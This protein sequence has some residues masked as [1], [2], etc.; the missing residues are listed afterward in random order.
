MC[1]FIE[2]Y[3][4]SLKKKHVFNKIV[5]F[6]PGDI[7]EIVFFRK[8]LPYTFEGICL[9]IK[10]KTLQDINSSFII[11]NVLSGIGIEYSI[12]YFYNRMYFLRR[13]DYKKKFYDIKRAKFF[14]LRN[15]LNRESQVK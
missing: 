7:L 11:R 3:N 2:N 14:Y 1:N 8:G 4:L 12:S 15:R 5:N 10:K 9:A 6:K 13:N